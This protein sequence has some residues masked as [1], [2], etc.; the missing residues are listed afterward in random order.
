MFYIDPGAFM[1]VT[2]TNFQ[3]LQ[4]NQNAQMIS[5][6]LRALKLEN[7]HLREQ[8]EK[9]LME[10]NAQI[11]LLAKEFEELRKLGKDL[12]CPY[13]AQLI[14]KNALICNFCQ[15]ALTVGDWEYLKVALKTKP[16]LA[17]KDPA[18]IK[19]LVAEIKRIDEEQR[20]L[21]ALLRLAKQQE[22][23]QK[24]LR[25]KVKLQ[26][27]AAMAVL[28][29]A[30]FLLYESQNLEKN[31]STQEIDEFADL[32]EKL[33]NLAH[34]GTDANEIEN[35]TKEVASLLPRYFELSRTPEQ[36]KKYQLEKQKSLITAEDSIRKANQV[37]KVKDVLNDEPKIAELR[38]DLRDKID[39]LHNAIKSE[40]LEEINLLNGEI[41]ENLQALNNLLEAKKSEIKAENERKR[42]EYLEKQR[43]ALESKS[44]EQKALALDWLVALTDMK[45]FLQKGIPVFSGGKPK[46]SD[47]IDIKQFH[48]EY[49]YKKSKFKLD[50]EFL[51][52]QDPSLVFSIRQALT[53][54][55]SMIGFRYELN[56]G[57]PLEGQKYLKSAQELGDI[58]ADLAL[59]HLYLTVGQLDAAKKVL[60]T[61]QKVMF[62]VWRDE[63]NAQSYRDLWNTWNIAVLMN[64]GDGKKVSDEKLLDLAR[65][66]LDKVAT[67]KPDKWYER[68]GYVGN[69]V[70]LS[71]LYA[72][73]ALRLNLQSEAS[74]ALDALSRKERKGCRK[75]LDH[76]IELSSGSGKELYLELS[77]ALE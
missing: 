1:Q 73:I 69:E 2:A 77:R 66:A 30:R 28:E 8:Q 4:N 49:E 7:G 6:Q 12:P 36:R 53:S 37:L 24:L 76:M 26:I 63:T 16:Y 11:A 61:S 32:F 23:Q 20:E 35:I 52:E 15:G 75:F 25:E 45:T 5:G 10:Q 38:N 68:F 74:S 18:T 34:F 13:C 70:L 67:V 39:L 46:K 58:Q 19:E 40:K 29:Q 43:E 31:L 54:I 17:A 41:R 44:T 65:K 33:K 51:F 3:T 72:A 62:E 48:R 21:V 47:K 50:Y 55:G 71:A 27:D 42:F 60:K 59:A 22:A 14:S 56:G 57:D 64:G 9:N